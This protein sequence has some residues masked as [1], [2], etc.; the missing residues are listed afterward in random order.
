[1]PPKDFSVCINGGQE[2]V[3]PANDPF[4]PQI[5]ADLVRKRDQGVLFGVRYD[6]GRFIALAL[7]QAQD[8]LR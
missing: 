2:D 8:D 5:K 1:M 4:G 6:S 3:F 7:V